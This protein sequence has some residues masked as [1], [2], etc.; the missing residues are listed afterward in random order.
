M[1]FPLVSDA[2]TQS[3]TVTSDSSSWTLTYPTNLANGDLILAFMALDNDGSVLNPSLP[4]GWISDTSELVGLSALVAKRKSDGTESGTFSVGLDSAQQGAW[5]IFRITGWEGTLGTA[6]GNVTASGAVV[7]TVG[8]DGTSTAPDPNL[9]NPANWVTE[10]TLWF[11]SAAAAA[12]PA[13]T[14]FPTSYTNTSSDVSGGASGAS[15]GI[16]RRENA[17]SSEN[18]SAFTIDASVVHQEWTVA[19]RPA[20]ATNASAGNAAATGI[21]ANASPTATGSTFQS[22]FVQLDAFQT[23]VELNAPAGNAAATGAAY[24]LSMATAANIGAG[25]G[26]GTAYAP[27]AGSLTQAAAGLASGTGA[28]QVAATSVVGTSG[29]G[30]A[31]GT[32]YTPMVNAIAGTPHRVIAGQSLR[33]TKTV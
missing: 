32:A 27:T 24:V 10:D 5:R 21:A 18:P 9:L 29:A 2:D 6:A 23:A 20:P 25:S 30:T 26:T 28:A 15:L 12:S 19:V 13:F 22:D 17:T 31:T 11:A 7:D 33:A 8:P 4:A 1:V 16:A 3:G 14:V